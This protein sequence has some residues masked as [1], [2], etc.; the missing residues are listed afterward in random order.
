MDIEA[1]LNTKGIRLT[2]NRILVLR[3][4]AAKNHPVSLTDLETEL[5][6]LEKSSIFRVLT[7]LADRGVLHAIEDGSGSLKYEICHT[8][9][10]GDDTD[11]H[12]HFYCHECGRT[13]CFETT[14][15]PPIELPAGFQADYVNYMVK[16]V[17]PDC[18]KKVKRDE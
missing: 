12:A 3:S 15:V 18:V 17:C 14:P 5:D 1:T 7:L 13:F 11:M 16:G 6:T 2:S 9:D 10:H 4:I 8:G